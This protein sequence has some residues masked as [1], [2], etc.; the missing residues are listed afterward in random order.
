MKART[1][2][3]LVA[4][5]SFPLALA[6]AR[7]DPVADFYRGKVV[8]LLIG[9]NVGGSYDIQARMVAR[10][11][12]AHI[13][14]NP[15]IVP[16]N[17]VG[18]GGLAM[19]NY[20]E[21]VAPH[22]GTALGMMA[23]TLIPY[24][25]VGGTGV[26][27]D[28]GKMNWIGSMESPPDV[29]VGRAASGLKSAADL[30]TRDVSIAASARGAITYVIPSML[31]EFAGARFKIVTGYQGSPSM[32]LAMERG[33][34]DAIVNSW[35]SL[36]AVKPEWFASGSAI[37][38]ARS[39]TKRADLQGIPAIESL[40]PD[41]E[42]R[43]A[44]ELVLAGNPLGRPLAFPR[45]VPPERVKAVRDA[46]DAVMKDPA[47]REEAAR[48]GYDLEPASGEELQRIVTRILATPKRI[49]DKAKPIIAP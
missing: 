24:Q 15:T 28:A 26:K 38:L 36:K 31:N 3:R 42:D 47:F 30:K 46:F 29:V 48:T 18:A 39:Q 35:P 13:P 10:Y 7:A 16:Q 22:D 45:D 25:V 11:I 5:A 33:E 8:N 27:F 1:F 2:A 6:A 17:M 19:A 49:A 34:V 37:I 20:L 44:M 4:A 12:G 9:I 41:P 32:N 43:Q 14:G 23:N 40:A 21:G